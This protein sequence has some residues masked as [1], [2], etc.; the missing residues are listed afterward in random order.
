MPVMDDSFKAFVTNLG[1]YNEG[2]LIGEWVKFP[3]TEE[4][5][6]KV[7]EQIGI[8]S[9]DEFGHVCDEWFITDYECP[10]YGVQK[11]LGEYESL[12][13]LNYLASLLDEM[14][15]HDLE[16]FV[17]IMESGCDEVSD[18]DDLINLTYNLD[19]YDFFPGIKD[20]DD[21]GRF[22]FEEGGYNEDNRFG[23]FV[24]YIDFERFGEDCA[25]N[26]NGKMT[27]AGYIRET[28]DSW[29]RFYDGTL[30]DIP[31][32]YR[33]TGGG[34]ELDDPGK[35]LVVVVEPGKEPRI[36]EI[37]SGLESLQGMV[38]GYIQA[39]YPYDDPVALICNEEGKLEGL[40]LNRALRDEDGDIYDIV[41]GA[42]LVVGLT[43]DNFGS[44]SGELAIKFSQEFKQPE[45][46]AKLGDK[47]VVIP[48]IS[49]EQQKQEA[50][51]QKD[52]EVNRDTS[53]LAVSGHVGTWHTIDHMEV[54]GHTFFL[55]EHDTYG[56][57]AACL[58]VDEHGKLSL[59]DVYDGFDEHTVDL[60]R[61]D[62]MAVDRMPDPSITTDEMKDYGYAWG[63]M[64]PLR[65]ETAA[66]IMK[67][68]SVYRLYSDNTEG[69][70]L[71]AKEIHDHAAKGGI[72]GVEK[73]E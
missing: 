35:I 13:K 53:G 1:K 3:T 40:P 11:M 24:D 20:H 64:L 10:F 44:L 46:F 57:E 48:M 56:G 30:D 17:A 19:R 21:L 33:V 47:I 59:S 27:D 29:N 68:C 61:Q 67:T 58:I 4:E 41:S 7:F 6:Q 42:F 45:S 32:E 69:L 38:G 23:S 51:E 66:E 54:D 52:F 14:P 37:D 34:E 50:K 62:V 5:M 31:D 72:L 70:V 43:E 8:G 39:I 65:E 36:E 26:E 49:E 25:I 28:G 60:L 12:D 15:K 73:V 16:K 22:Y 2:E 18:I 71:D 55:M 9:K 63:G